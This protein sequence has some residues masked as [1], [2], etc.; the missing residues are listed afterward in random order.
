MST[1]STCCESKNIYVIVGFARSGTSV[2]TRGLQALGIDLGDHILEHKENNRWN[3]TGFFED[4]EII[5]HIN[6]KVYQ[7]LGVS[8]R[9]IPIIHENE[10]KQHDFLEIK[11]Y[12][13]NMLHER[14]SNTHHWGFKNPST[15]KIIPFWISLFDTEKLN[16]HYIIALRN[17]LSSAQSFSKL[18]HMD[19]E[20]GL[21]LWLSHIIPAIDDTAGRKRIVVSYELMMQDPIKQL[22]RIKSELNILTSHHDFDSYTKQ[23]LNDSLHHHRYKNE[24]LTSHPA[25]SIAP[26]CSKVYDI[27]MKTASDELKLNSPEFIAAWKVIKQEFEKY[28]PIYCYIDTILKKNKALK[29]TVRDMQ[30]S[31]IWKLFYPLRWTNDHLRKIRQKKRAKFRLETSYE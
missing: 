3:P 5:Y 26:L 12:A 19:I 28:Y 17:P 29:H 6:T 14:F 24:D 21:M 31:I 11:T 18:T 15:A 20:V 13:S 2:I 7:K 9:G 22:L 8:I 4:K 25:M 30:R 27:L 23:F 10:F 1:N 16:D